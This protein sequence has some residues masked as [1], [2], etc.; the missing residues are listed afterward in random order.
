MEIAVE[1]DEILECF[2][3]NNYMLMTLF[4]YIQC[5][6]HKSVFGLLFTLGCDVIE[7]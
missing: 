2:T 6:L 3:I 7:L 5:L 1:V 4:L